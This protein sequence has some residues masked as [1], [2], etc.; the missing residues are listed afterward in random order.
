M[1]EAKI[2][3]KKDEPPTA[4]VIVTNPKYLRD[5]TKNY[6]WEILGRT[7]CSYTKEA[8][9][10]LEAHGENLKKIEYIDIPNTAWKERLFTLGAS[11]VP[12]IFRDG[13]LIGSLGELEMYY[14]RTFVPM[15]D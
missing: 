2:P 3:L 15:Q 7:D 9:K 1:S 4:E 14:K 12:A 13:H 5:T 8:V 10:L 11:Y 6:T